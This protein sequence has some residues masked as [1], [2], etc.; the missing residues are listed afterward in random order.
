M[1]ER[2]AFQKYVLGV[3]DTKS[4]RMSGTPGLYVFWSAPRSKGSGRKPRRAWV[5]VWLRK[6]MRQKTADKGKSLARE[7]SG[8]I[9]SS[10]QKQNRTTASSLMPLGMR[11]RSA[12]GRAQG[13]DL[14]QSG[15]RAWVLG[16][17]GGFAYCMPQARLQL[18]FLIFS[19]SRI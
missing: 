1:L 4:P 6:Q 11:S 10:K 9:I 15:W 17:H 5:A 3:E 14:L 7:T 12:G 19:F 18:S 2:G 13:A 16:A 8:F